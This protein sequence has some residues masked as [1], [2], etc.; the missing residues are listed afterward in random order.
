MKGALKS[1][2]SPANAQPARRF[3]DLIDDPHIT[4]ETPTTFSLHC[5]KGRHEVKIR[6]Q[7]SSPDY[8]DISAEPKDAGCGTNV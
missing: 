1:F 2:S 3:A 6:L 4:H 7:R 8:I 5:Q